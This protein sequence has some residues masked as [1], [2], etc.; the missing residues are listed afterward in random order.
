M[1]QGVGHVL[2]LPFEARSGPN[3]KSE[4]EFLA[5][6]WRWQENATYRNL[7]VVR[8]LSRGAIL[9]VAKGPRV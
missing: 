9:A 3:R 4:S 6:M 7:L 2:L 1:T 5:G 8:R